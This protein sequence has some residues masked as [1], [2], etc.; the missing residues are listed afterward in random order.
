MELCQTNPDC[1]GYSVNALS[2]NLLSKI[3]ESQAKIDP[4]SGKRIAN[5]SN[6]FYVK[7]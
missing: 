7:I 2:C 4:L 5:S 6:D 1:A 3:G